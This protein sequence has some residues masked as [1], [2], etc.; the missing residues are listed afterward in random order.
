MARDRPRAC[1]MLNSEDREQFT[2]PPLRL[3]LRH[4]VRVAL[5]LMDEPMASLD[6]ARRNELRDLLR[7]FVREGRTLVLA[8][9][10]EESRAPAPPVYCT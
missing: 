5:L 6:A 10:D 9:H 1:A 7:G 4:A 2:R 3:L 8:T